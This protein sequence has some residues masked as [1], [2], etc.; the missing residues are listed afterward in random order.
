M[1]WYRYECISCSVFFDI[2]RSIHDVTEPLCCGVTAR[3]VYNNVGAIFRGTGWGKDA[4]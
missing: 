1:A 4:K 3:R 2:Q